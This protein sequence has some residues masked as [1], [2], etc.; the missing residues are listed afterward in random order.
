MTALTRKR[1]LGKTDS[2]HQRDF[3]QLLVIANSYPR[4]H[5]QKKPATTDWL[6]FCVTV[7]YVTSN[8]YFGRAENNVAY[9]GYL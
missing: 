5:M 1:T 6:F 3:Y 7:S 9:V 2:S 8:A 4:Y